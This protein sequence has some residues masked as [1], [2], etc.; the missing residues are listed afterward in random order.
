MEAPFTRDP[1]CPG[2]SCCLGSPGAGYSCRFQPPIKGNWPQ[3]GYT[4]TKHAWFRHTRSWAQL[5]RSGS[6]HKSSDPVSVVLGMTSVHKRRKVA[7]EIA[8]SAHKAF[9]QY[10]KVDSILEDVLVLS[11]C[12]S[13]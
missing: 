13:Q 10:V 4:Y 8:Q 6:T 1:E 5:T 2:P 11:A 3:F 7:K 12:Y 9:A